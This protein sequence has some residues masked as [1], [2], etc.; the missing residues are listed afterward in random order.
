[1]G[2]DV[3][4]PRRELVIPEGLWHPVETWTWVSGSEGTGRIELGDSRP[5][6]LPAIRVTGLRLS[7]PAGSTEHPAF[8]RW[9]SQSL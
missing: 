2:L 4:E 9:L 6:P 7:G 8:S 1:M 3:P 5:S